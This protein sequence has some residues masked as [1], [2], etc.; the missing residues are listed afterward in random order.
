MLIR[1]EEPG[2]EVAI[3]DLTKVAFAPMPFADDTDHLLPEMLRKDGDLSLSLVAIEEG[4]IIGH[5]AFSPATIGDE[6]TGWMGLGPI[7]VTPAR[8][9]QGIGS[10][11]CAEG[12]AMLES[13]GALGV[14]LIGNPKVYEPMGF[15]SDGNLTYRELPPKL[16]QYKCLHGAPAKGVVTF[17]PALEV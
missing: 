17:A 2:D 14:V 13:Q 4:H 3:R 8:Q 10:A 11:L 7:S 1:P 16:V 6:P 15:M 9:R 5:A 12:C